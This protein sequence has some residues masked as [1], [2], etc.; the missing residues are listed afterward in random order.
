MKHTI[1]ALTYCIVA[2]NAQ[3]QT[4]KTQLY[5]IPGLGT[6]YHIFEPYQFDTSK[7]EIHHIRYTLPDAGTSMTSYAHQ[8]S[9]QIDTSRPFVL[10]G[11]SLGGML[12]VEMADF[13]KADNVFIIASAKMRCELPFRYRFQ[14]KL[15]IQRLISGNVI[16]KSTQLLQPIVEPDRNQ[17]KEVFI[18]MLDEKDPE[19]MKGA[20][21]MIL[22]W[23]REE[24]SDK[25]IHI[26][27]DHDH[28]IPIRNVKPDYVVPKGSHVM[29]L[30]ESGQINAIIANELNHK[31]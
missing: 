2:L 14:S 28:T 25:V 21:D 10:I 26:H 31:H 29:C 18:D 8:L 12:A 4:V 23:N 19:F 16:K 27:G 3:S 20:T 1:L 7:Y 17:A 5:F 22:G 9:Y 13:L 30:T 6:D 11:A 15:P 24:Y